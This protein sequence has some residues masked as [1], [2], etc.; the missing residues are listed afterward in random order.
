MGTKIEQPAAVL[1]MRARHIGADG[2]D[3]QVE[4]HMI[5]RQ[6]DNCV[7]VAEALSAKVVAEYVEHGG[8]GGIE[9]RSPVLMMLDE[10]RI[11]RDTNYVIIDT[12]DR[13]A[14]KVADWRQIELELEAAGAT[15]IVAQEFLQSRKEVA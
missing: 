3:W 11:Y 8:A 6:R 7:K 5:A 2:R 9:H 10:L 4:Y 14:R 15:L 12:R 13:L 1:F